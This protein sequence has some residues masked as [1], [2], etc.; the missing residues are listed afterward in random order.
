MRFIANENISANVIHALRQHQHD[1]LAVKE[2]MQSA[3]DDAVLARA[4]EEERVLISHDK[5]FGELAFR[6]GLPAAC[7][8]I[9]L[10]LSGRGAPEDNG[11]AIEALLE[12]D[13]WSGHFAVVT[14]DRIRMRPIE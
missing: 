6:K 13:D 11:R 5:D 2:A 9:L 14:Q 10:R 12:R 3:S 4:A 8:I 1:V 7:G